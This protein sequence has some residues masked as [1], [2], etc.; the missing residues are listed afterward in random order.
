MPIWAHSSTLTLC[1]YMFD[2]LTDLQKE[3]GTVT[4]QYEL[5]TYCRSL[6]PFHTWLRLLSPHILYSTCSTI[7]LFT[8]TLVVNPLLFIIELHIASSAQSLLSHNKIEDLVSSKR[9][10]THNHNLRPF[11]YDPILFHVNL[12]FPIS[13]VTFH[14]TRRLIPIITHVNLF[15]FPFLRLPCNKFKMSFNSYSKDTKTSLR[16]MK[17]YAPGFVGSHPAPIP[18]DKND[19]ISVSLSILLRL[20][21]SHLSHFSQA[22]LIKLWED[23][24]SFQC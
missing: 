22:V 8:Y 12:Y 19:K 21:Q 4:L 11:I 14:H 5:S 1:V 16:D 9:I 6:R 23:K 10:T 13:Q 24:K 15:F 20:L 18:V 7:C 2:C 17:Q 3:R